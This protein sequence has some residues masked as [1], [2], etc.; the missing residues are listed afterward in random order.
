MFKY[1]TTSTPIEEEEECESFCEHP[2][3]SFAPITKS[4]QH[5]MYSTYLYKISGK[6][7][8]DMNFE[9]YKD[10][11]TKDSDHVF[12]I[13]ESISSSKCL[14]HNFV[15]FYKPQK[16][17]SIADGQHRY[18]AMKIINSSILESLDCLVLLIDF[19]TASE[20]YIYVLFKNINT[21]KG[22]NC[23][24]LETDS[25]IREY[26]LAAQKSFGKH[27]GK[28]LIDDLLTK[29][30]KNFHRLGFLLLKNA[31]KA[32][33][34][35]IKSLSIPDFVEA[36]HTYNSNYCVDTSNA[37]TTVLKKCAKSKFYLGLEFP[38]WVERL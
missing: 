8:I 13:A 15:L 16:Y 24:D 3:T 6:Q 18:E 20:D 36:L 23:E 21:V 34:S 19:Q 14:F 2:L 25:H 33:W 10:Q 11:R 38:G 9:A 29:P 28:L 27:Y 17:I 37:P 30:E 31:I 22:M 5:G 1:F 35:R 4:T 32:N 7:F 26:V 12:R